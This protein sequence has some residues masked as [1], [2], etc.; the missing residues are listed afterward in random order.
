[1]ELEDLLAAFATATPMID[2]WRRYPDITPDED[3]RTDAWA[4]Q[5]ASEEF[6]AFARA[7]GFHAVLITVAEP[8]PPEYDHYWSR[9]DNT[10]V[11]WTARQYHNLKH[12]PAAKHQDLPCPLTWPA[13]EPHPIL[14]PDATPMEAL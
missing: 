1:M 10:N 12:P 11:D 9:V 2:V 14:G 13:G 6:V 3:D 4:C 7:H 8:R 5:Q